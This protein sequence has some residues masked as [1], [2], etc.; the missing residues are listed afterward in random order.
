MYKVYRSEELSVKPFLSLVTFFCAADVLKRPHSSQ[1]KPKKLPSSQAT[2]STRNKIDDGFDVDRFDS[3]EDWSSD[4]EGRISVEKQTK[5]REFFQV[6]QI[7]NW[8]VDT[9]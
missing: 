8:R 7:L 2:G 6:S 1:V 5:I 9:R 4:E 3:G